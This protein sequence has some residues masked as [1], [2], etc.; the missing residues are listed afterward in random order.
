MWVGGAGNPAVGMGSVGSWEAPS[1][2]WR[3]DTQQQ[4][5]RRNKELVW[6]SSKKWIK[7][8]R[9]AW[10]PGVRMASGRPRLPIAPNQRV[11]DVR[12]C[13]SL[14]P[15]HRHISG[16]P[17]LP[18]HSLRKIS[19]VLSLCLAA[20]IS[21]PFQQTHLLCRPAIKHEAA[22]ERTFGFQEKQLS[23]PSPAQTLKAQSAPESCSAPR[24]RAASI[25]ASLAATAL[26]SAE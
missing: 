16:L 25:L 18:S 8:E 6:G 4:R 9:G 14:S 11:T 24:H 7:M 1:Y 13:C 26:S 15:T 17:G 19:K 10:V 12:S 21:A 20:G 3:G 5:G 22:T 2:S 23:L